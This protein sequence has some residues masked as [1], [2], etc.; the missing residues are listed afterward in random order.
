MIGLSDFD[1]VYV[2]MAFLV[3]GYVY[4]VVRGH[5][6]PG[7]RSRGNESIIRLLSV[8]TV[9]FAVWAWAVYLVV[10]SQDAP[11]W[12][13]AAVWTFAILVSPALMG[14]LSGLMTKYQ[15]LRWLYNRI[16]FSPA[17]IVP[18]SWD[19]AFSKPHERFVIVVMNDGRRFAGLWGKDSFAS[20][21]PGERDIF[22]EKVYKIG[23]DDEPWTET[24]RS[25]LIRAEAIRSV[26]FI[27]V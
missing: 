5:L 26:E 12:M 14:L 9:N 13:H 17:H 4:F 1:A 8:S 3:P 7:H 21:E 25:V 27:P 11:I 16:G 18:T 23:A 15:V 20:D 10:E 22:I 2:A 24:N 19:Y 6:V